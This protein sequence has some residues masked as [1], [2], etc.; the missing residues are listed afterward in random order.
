MVLRGAMKELDRDPPAQ[1]PELRPPGYY[2]G[3]MTGGGKPP[4]WVEEALVAALKEWPKE[5]PK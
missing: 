5:P 4:P 1:P 3:T 2:T